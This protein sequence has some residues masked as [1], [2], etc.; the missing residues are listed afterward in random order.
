MG[1]RSYIQ[2]LT[3]HHENEG[4]AINLRWMMYTVYAVLGVCYTQGQLM[5]MMWRDREGSLNFVY[6]NDS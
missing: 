5:V 3:R 6:Y 2:A 1:S 4:N